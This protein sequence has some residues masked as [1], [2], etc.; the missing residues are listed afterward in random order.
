[1]YLSLQ[2]VKTA[3]A[4]SNQRDS[5]SEITIDSYV[6]AR[7]RIHSYLRDEKT[8]ASDDKSVNSEGEDQNWTP[9]EVVVPEVELEHVVPVDQDGAGDE[10]DQQQHVADVQQPQMAKMTSENGNVKNL[11][12]KVKVTSKS[13]KWM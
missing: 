1:M 10:Q 8:K 7:A 13:K 5:L 12:W 4:A 3:K 6:V 11:Q 2:A 9:E